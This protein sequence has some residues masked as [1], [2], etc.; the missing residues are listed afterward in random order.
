MDDQTWQIA[1]GL[2]PASPSEVIAAKQRFLAARLPI[3]GE[4]LPHEAR[5]ATEVPAGLSMPELFRATLAA[6]RFGRADYSAA[7]P[8][9]HNGAAVEG[10]TAAIEKKRQQE[11]KR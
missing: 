5:R 2:I 1:F 10:W 8:P 7:N 9:R 4:P 6:F 3:T 11:A